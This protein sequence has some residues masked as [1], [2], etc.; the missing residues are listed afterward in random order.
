M[1]KEAPRRW[2]S[3]INDKQLCSLD[4]VLKTQKFVTREH[5]G[6]RESMSLDDLDDLSIVVLSVPL[7]V[8]TE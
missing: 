4:D 2:C 7:K 3:R 6:V 5:E 1:R 8:E